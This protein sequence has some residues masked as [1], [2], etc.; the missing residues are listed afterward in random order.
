MRVTTEASTSFCATSAGN[1]Q[2][3]RRQHC[4]PRPEAAY[5]SLVK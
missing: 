2:Q 4:R 1:G 5:S 3:H